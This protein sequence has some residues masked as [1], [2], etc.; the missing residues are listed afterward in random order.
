M[1]KKVPGDGYGSLKVS[2]V[3]LSTQLSENYIRDQLK[4]GEL[5]G[6][7]AGNDWRVE[8]DDLTAW[9]E[10]RKGK[11]RGTVSRL[12]ALEGEGR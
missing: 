5:V 4:A 8:P 3:A 12:R 10:R 7:R 2:D 9:I 11:P 1:S 6:W